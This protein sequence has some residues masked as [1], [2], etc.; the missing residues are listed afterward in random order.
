MFFI[1]KQ[2]TNT[3][4]HTQNFDNT[5]NLVFAINLANL[6]LVFCTYLTEE[7]IILICSCMFYNFSFSFYLFPFTLSLSVCMY[8]VHVSVSVCARAFVWMCF[9]VKRLKYNYFV[10]VM[11]FFCSRFCCCCCLFIYFLARLLACFLYVRHS[12][13]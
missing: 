12:K 4:T 5:I 1:Q 7:H 6:L 2:H 11:Q 9:C 13:F 3:N 10:T 8:I